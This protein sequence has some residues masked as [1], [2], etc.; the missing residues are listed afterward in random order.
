[1][2][3]ITNYFLAGL[4][5]MLPTVATIYLL[6]TVF[7][8]LDGVTGRVIKAYLGR[9]LP[10]LGA[11]VTVLAIILLGLITTNVAG[12]KLVS[13]WDKILQ[14]LPFVK[15]VYTTVK[16]VTDVIANPNKN[17]FKQMVLLEWPSPGL[18]TIGYLV[19][20]ASIDG[21]ASIFVPTPPNPAG[22][23]VILTTPDK[24]RVLDMSMEEG[25]KF[26]LSCGVVANKEQ[27]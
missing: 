19:S 16:Q 15:S 22:G 7:N 27:L 11:V 2:K 6:K 17:S 4:F 1:M 3:R 21:L 14:Q 12:R 9:T 23:F 20:E 8:L 18:W 13:W 25:M 24:Y 10:G 26:I 5:A